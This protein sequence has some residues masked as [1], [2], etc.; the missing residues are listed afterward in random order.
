MIF[1]REVQPFVNSIYEIHDLC[2]ELEPIRNRVEELLCTDCGWINRNTG[3][4]TQN[5]TSLEDPVIIPIFDKITPIV[6]SIFTSWGIQSDPK[7]NLYF[8]NVDKF[9]GYSNSHSHINCALSGVVYVTIPE[10]SGNIIFT[11]PDAQ[12]YQFKVLGSNNP[13]TASAYT[14]TPRENMA[15]LFPSFVKHTVEPHLFSPD[16]KRV[17]IAFD[18]TF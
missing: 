11:R 16:D 12:E 13:Y 1:Y 17:S 3:K 9:G 2:L 4:Q 7:L 14:V 8:I 6:K 15:L 10:N 18:Y 5:I